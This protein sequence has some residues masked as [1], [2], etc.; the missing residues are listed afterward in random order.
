[1]T[2]IK[3]IGFHHCYDQI[4]R[5]NFGLAGTNKMEYV[6]KVLDKDLNIDVELVSPSWYSSDSQ[7]SNNA[8]NLYFKKISYPFSLKSRNKFFGILNIIYSNSWLFF[9]LLLRVKKGEKILV[10]HSPWLGIPLILAK[11]IKNFKIILEVEEIYS[12]VWKL[13]KFIESVE[14][15]LFE[16]SESYIAVSDELAGILPD[17]PKVVLYGSYWQVNVNKEL[18]NK[19]DTIEVVYSGAIDSYLGGAFNLAKCGRYLNDNINIHILGYASEDEIKKLKNL[20]F[21]VN[22]EAERQVVQYH[23]L[24]V[25]EN[26]NAFLQSCHIGV[27]PQ[28]EGS[29]MDSAFPS[30][31]LNYLSNNLIVVSTNVLG[32]R[33]SKIENNIIFTKDDKVESIAETLNGIKLND[34]IN[35]LE[36]VS[37]LECDFISNLNYLL[38]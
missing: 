34:K 16:I 36:I 18:K 24:M 8:T 21:E 29:H 31:I 6:A 2:N 26:F 33:K 7:L 9:Y 19:S 27:N 14:N 15:K 25:G 5:K 12:K 32:V 1:M 28:N 30:K 35:T 37:K 4:L 3:Y 13:S 38:D 23:G 11:K 17:K 10:Y 20:I 22:R